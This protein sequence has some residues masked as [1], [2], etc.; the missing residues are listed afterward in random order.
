MES[1]VVNSNDL[2]VFS[3]D[4]FGNV[5]T[6]VE[7]GAVLFCAS[8][9]AKMLGYS[10]PADAVSTHCKG[11]VI[12]RLP[13]TGGAQDVKFIPESDLYRLAFRSKLKTAESFTDWVTNEV[14]PSIRKYGMYATTATLENLMADPD[15]GIQLFTALRDERRARE[16]A[17]QENQRLSQQAVLDA[18]KVAFANAVELSDRTIKIGDFAKVMQSAGVSDMGRNTFY[19][20]LRSAKI[21]DRD[22]IPYQRYMD[23][24]YFEVSEFLR[25]GHPMRVVSVTG[26][27]Q[28]YLYGKLLKRQDV[29]EVVPS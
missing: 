1:K 12:R 21:L 23:G 18:P 8:D 2:M 16:Q 24:G 13:T 28:H 3:R 10:R 6:L 9:V 4:D 17:E 29:A 27:G 14:L 7:D 15:F 11:S 25:N 22:N 19:K 5:R 26:R 20:W